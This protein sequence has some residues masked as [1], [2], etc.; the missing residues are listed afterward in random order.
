MT[1]SRI[2]ALGASLPSRAL[3]NEELSRS[4]GR[5]ATWIEERTGIR[6]RRIAAPDETAATLGLDASRQA[7][8]AAGRRGSDV[9]LIICA[10]VTAQPR[11][12][13]TACLIQAGLDS[14][15]AAFDLNAGCSGF[16]VALAQADAAIRSGAAQR[17]LVVGAE[18]MSRITDYGDPKTAILFGDGAGAALLEATEGPIALGPF[19]LFSDGSEPDLLFVDEDAGTIRMEGRRVYRAAVAAMAASVGHILAATGTA[20]DRVDLVI[21]HQA[22]RRILDAVSSRLGLPVEKM[23][24]NIDRYGNTSSASIP[25]ALAEAQSEG[26][27][28]DGDLVVLTAFGAGFVWGAGLLR[29]GTGSHGLPELVGAGTA[30]A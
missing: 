2:V 7:L 19:E 6:S 12:P 24:S 17:V 22:N 28:K 18:V 9:D 4:I 20:V 13:A 5:D 16:L 30:D 29:W 8:S 21:A 1:G 25:I 26:S 27:M 23:Y 3:T 11:F 15:A 14:K 10:T